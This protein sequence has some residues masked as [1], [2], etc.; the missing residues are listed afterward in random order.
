VSGF[1]TDAGTFAS[2][3][4]S[5]AVRPL[6][7]RAVVVGPAA[8]RPRMVGRVVFVG[9]DP[10]VF[11]PLSKPGRPFL[12]M[13]DGDASWAAGVGEVWAPLVSVRESF[14][15]TSSYDGGDWSS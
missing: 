2:V 8:V 10:A 6:D 14:A 4:A 9:A 3:F 13:G 12:S 5:D 1:A 15:A 7:V 11:G